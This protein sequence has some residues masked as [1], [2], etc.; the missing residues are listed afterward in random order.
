ME[1]RQ[2]EP[3]RFVGVTLDEVR[4]A[5]SGLYEVTTP[6]GVPVRLHEM[7]LIGLVHDAAERTLVMDFVY[8]DPEWTLQQRISGGRWAEVE[9]HVHEQFA[10]LMPNEAAALATAWRRLVAED[11]PSADL[12]ITASGDLVVSEAALALLRQYKLDG[13]EVRESRG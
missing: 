5:G 12:R 2:R 7:S 8:D 11:D 9:V 10:A 13:C 1:N 4:A 6:G 3:T